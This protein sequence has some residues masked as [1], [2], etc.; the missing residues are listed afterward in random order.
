[1]EP[2]S[3]RK[4]MGL[5]DNSWWRGVPVLFP[6]AKPAQ[7]MLGVMPHDSTS[8]PFESPASH[9]V[10]KLHVAPILSNHFD[11]EQGPKAANLCRVTGRGRSC[12]SAHMAPCGLPGCSSW[13]HPLNKTPPNTTAKRGT[14]Y[15]T[16][17]NCQ[18]RA[19]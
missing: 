13:G 19:V 15:P 4:M 5:S 1:M 17:G 10:Q 6:F 9:Q 14:E 18:K 3:V 16:R 2:A 7:S 11:S 8:I 12:P